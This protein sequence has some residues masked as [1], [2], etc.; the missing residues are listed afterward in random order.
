MLENRLLDR[1]EAAAYLAVSP[2]T[3]ARHVAPKVPVVRV[4]GCVRYCR[5]DLDRWIDEHKEG[6]A[7]EALPLRPRQQRS[8][9]K[10][11]WTPEA[12]AMRDRLNAGIER[13]RKKEAE[14]LARGSNAR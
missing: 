7:V 6:G 13:A 8:A 11:E 1:E 14:K 9:F 3:F 5:E 2:W 4:G 10:M 12:L